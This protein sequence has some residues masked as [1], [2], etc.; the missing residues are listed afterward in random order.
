M[1]LVKFANT[2]WP[3]GKIAILITNDDYGKALVDQ[4]NSDYQGTTI[5][6]YYIAGEK[7]FR[8]NLTK[9]KEKKPDVIIFSDR[10]TAISALLVKQAKELG[11]EATFIS[12]DYVSVEAKEF[13]EI[14]GKGSEG[15]IYLKPTGS[16]ISSDLPQTKHFFESFKVKYG[17][18]PKVDVG[19]MYDAINMLI[20]P[21]KQCGDDTSCI[22]EKLYQV[23]NFHSIYGLIHIDENGDTKGKSF[24]FKTIKNGQFVPYEE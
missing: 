3:A 18:L 16:E 11:I 23:K 7:D 20:D 6:E 2:H 4:F 9:I 14:T 10:S 24:I 13:F 17:T 5:N 15:L 22:K 19:T 8:T 12:A 21:L 1:H